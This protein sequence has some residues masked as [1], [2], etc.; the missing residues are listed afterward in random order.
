M[1]RRKGKDCKK[2]RSRNEK[3]RKR[4]QKHP[5]ETEKNSRNNIE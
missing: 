3:K 5:K 2:T 4:I 1:K